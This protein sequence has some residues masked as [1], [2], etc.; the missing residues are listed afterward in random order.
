MPG[1]GNS[2][3]P[4]GNGKTV[5]RH[6]RHSAPASSPELE[7]NSKMHRNMAWLKAAKS[8][9]D[10]PPVVTYLQS[11]MERRAALR[12]RHRDHRK[13]IENQERRDA[14]KARLAQ[15]KADKRS[16]RGS[17]PWHPKGAWLPGVNNPKEASPGNRL[18]V[19]EE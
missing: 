17:K 12:L 10:I 11:Y 4:R 14:G 8:D 5:P 15:Q 3:Q 7:T 9:A 18:R 13:S 16:I 6:R 1:Y 19:P 2:R